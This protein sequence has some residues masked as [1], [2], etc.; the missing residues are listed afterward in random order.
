MTF[1]DKVLLLKDLYAAFNRRDIELVLAALSK[2]VKWPNMT[3]N[4]TIQG[5]AEIRAYWQKQ[6]QTIQSIVEPFGFEE[7]NGDVAVQVHQRVTVVETNQ[8]MESD[9][10]HTYTFN[11][12]LVTAMVVS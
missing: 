4:I 9:V 1:E 3:E 6:F 2:D 12:D 7:R 5:H 10:T 11:N 8:V